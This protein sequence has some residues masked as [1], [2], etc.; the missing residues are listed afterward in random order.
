VINDFFKI[1]NFLEPEKNSEILAWVQENQYEFI[2][3]TVSTGVEDYRRSDVAF[4]FPLISTFKSR[5]R[6]IVP[7]ALAALGLEMICFGDIE[8]QLTATGDGGFFKVHTDKGVT[9]P[10]RVVSYV[11]YLNSTPK[12]FTGGELRLY[13][14]EGSQNFNQ[15]EPT[16]NSLVLFR[17]DCA[18]EVMPVVSSGK[19]A[20]NRFTINGWVNEYKDDT[21]PSLLIA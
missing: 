4:R 15:I 18:H 8:S 14:S 21:Q 1:E 6:S 16:N 17:S 5:I 10:N 7:P 13:E 9:V 3:S 19:F 11:Y 12:P 2:P 20:D